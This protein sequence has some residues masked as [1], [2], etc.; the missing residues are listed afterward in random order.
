M[1]RLGYPT[2]VLVIV[3]AFK[4]PAALVLMLPGVR[5]LKEWVYAGAF[6]TYVV[7][8]VS[9]L[10]VSDDFGAAVVPSAFAALVCVARWLRAPTSR[11]MVRP[12]AHGGREV[13]Y[14]ATTS[15]VAAACLF[16]GILWTLH[17]QP[18]IKIMLRLG[19]PAYFMSIL[20]AA[21]F[22]AGVVL[23]A[24]RSPRLKEW[25][26]AGLVFNYVGAIASHVAVGDRAASMLAPC[27]L[28]ALVFASWLLRPP[29]RRATGEGWETSR[30][31]ALSG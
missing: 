6:I 30:E 16:G 14:W 20:G 23:L 27:V 15:V 9:H 12:A 29:A 3:G 11:A 10:A 28:L 25:A 18:F 24:P 19:Y 31:V 1:T 13:A 22:A 21:Y 17:A 5:R 4:V 2:Y 26:Y 7:A 8:T